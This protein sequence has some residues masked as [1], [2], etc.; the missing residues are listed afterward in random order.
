M[1]LTQWTYRSYQNEEKLNDVL[2]KVSDLSF[3]IYKL[4]PHMSGVGAE[5]GDGMIFHTNAEAS[6]GCSQL[7]HKLR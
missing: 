7:S 1:Y 6:I 2:S 4:R 5:H 3:K